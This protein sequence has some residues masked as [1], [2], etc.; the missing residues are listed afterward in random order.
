MKEKEFID[1]IK[2]HSGII[3]KI[4]ILYTNNTED[5][6]DL[7]QEILYQSW[8]SFDCFKGN[9][10]FS[11]WLYKVA[12]NTA[13]TFLRKEKKQVQA[14]EHYSDW[15]SIQE[16]EP[17]KSE[18]L[19]RA[20]KTLDESDRVIITLHLDGYSNDEIADICGITKNNAS[21]KLYRSKQEIINLLKK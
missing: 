11:T 8:K 16:N 19:I 7:Y 18:D 6:A 14:I 1:L 20:L 5:K 2:K 12:I 15:L 10:Q 17:E 9:S 3:Y 21:V 4:I 13:L